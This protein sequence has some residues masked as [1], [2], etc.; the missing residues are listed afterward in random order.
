ML[1]KR[2]ALEQALYLALN[3]PTDEQ[4]QRASQPAERIAAGMDPVVVERAKAEAL[5]R[6]E[7][8]TTDL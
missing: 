2:E 7:G 1:E 4:A 5:E 6:A 3:A 8:I